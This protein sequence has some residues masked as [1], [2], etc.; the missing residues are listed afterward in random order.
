[1]AGVVKI[2]ERIGEKVLVYGRFIDEGKK[3]VVYSGRLVGFGDKF[4][5][6]RNCEAYLY[7]YKDNKLEK[8]G[9]IMKVPLNVLHWGV[10]ASVAFIEEE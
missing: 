7:E 10:I 8:K 6:L 2:K 1:M 4:V 3:I 5:V 9:L